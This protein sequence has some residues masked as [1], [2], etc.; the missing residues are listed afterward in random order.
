MAPEQA[1]G[2]PVD[3]RAD[4]YALATVAYRA[5][6]GQPPFSGRDVP[7]ILYSVVHEQPARPSSLVKLSRDVDRVLAIGM[8]KE[9]A[10]RFAS[11]L[12]LA[13]AL[14]AAVHGKLA[15]EL[16]ERGDR[17]L[18]PSAPSPGPAS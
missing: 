7:A 10:E 3:H 6:T 4:A 8:A 1:R 2:R 9:P 17:L 13:D 15:R 5:I 18:S 14:A 12:E 16:R 11:A